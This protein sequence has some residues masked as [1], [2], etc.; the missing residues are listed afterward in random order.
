MVIRRHFEL[1]AELD[2]LRQLADNERQ[3][4]LDG[5]LVKLSLEQGRELEEFQS[6]SLKEAQAR[7]NEL[8]K[9]V[10]MQLTLLG[11]RERAADPYW[12]SDLS[13]WL[14]FET[15]KPKD[16]LLLLSGVSPTAAIVDWTFENFM[17]AVVDSPRIRAASDLNAIYDHYDLP[18]RNSW[19]EEFATVKAKLRKA[20]SLSEADRTRLAEELSS[21]ERLR[22]GP[23]LIRRETELRYRSR[24]L[25]ALSSQWFSGGHDA[26]RRYTPEHFV[27]WARARGFVPEWCEWA[28]AHGL[29]G[30]DE[31]RSGSELFDPDAEDYPELLHIAVRAWEFAKM[32]NT[33]TPK[34]RIE[35]FLSDRYPKLS[36]NAR[37]GIAQ[38]ANWQRIGGRP[39][40]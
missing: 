6:L 29:L 10:L 37:E 35:A 33:G 26:E 14:G 5:P 11:I 17:G 12:F 24:I 36:S 15:W 3:R 9:E 7:H 16:A 4:A 38:V 20:D 8:S 19:D 28:T 22:D 25:S 2:A 34:Q 1:E 13:K 27:S 21:L 18:E 39:K 31:S 23:D 32:G 30:A 40:T